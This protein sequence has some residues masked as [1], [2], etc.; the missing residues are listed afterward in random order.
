MFE[1]QLITKSNQMANDIK[2]LDGMVQKLVNQDKKEES[3]H[4][5]AR[6]SSIFGFMGGST[7]KPNHQNPMKEAQDNDQLRN[8]NATPM[9]TGERE[10][11]FV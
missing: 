6:R 4:E 8:R 1:K 10:N 9:R 7:R 3:K 2:K 11:R 5:D